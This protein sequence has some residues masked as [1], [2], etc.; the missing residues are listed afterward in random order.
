M[1]LYFL[2]AC[3]GALGSV[4]RFFVSDMIL[5]RFGE[6]FPW[7]TLLINVTGSAAIGYIATFATSGEA[8]WLGSAEGRLFLMVGICGGYTTFSAFSLQTLNLIRDGDWLRAGA[9]IAA[10]VILCVAG[11]GL[12]HAL[13][14]STSAR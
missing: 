5:R 1:R 4:L 12:G 7:G 10:S 2:I 6:S 14:A 8:R 9:Y 11:A 13:G 3:G